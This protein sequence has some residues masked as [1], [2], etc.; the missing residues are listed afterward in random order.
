VPNKSVA[1]AHTWLAGEM[2][3][4]QTITSAVKIE[5]AQ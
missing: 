4:W 1:D 5:V 3:H 2:K